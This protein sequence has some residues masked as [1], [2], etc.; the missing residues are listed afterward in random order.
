MS[1]IV[2]STITIRKGYRHEV[3]DEEGFG[4]ELER[5]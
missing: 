1:E 5:A 4:E 2:L 3:D